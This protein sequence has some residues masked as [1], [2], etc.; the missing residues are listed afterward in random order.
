MVELLK[1][2]Y[3]DENGY[4]GLYDCAVQ[5]EKDL[6]LEAVARNRYVTDLENN[7]LV[8]GGKLLDREPPC[9]AEFSE[10]RWE[11]F[12][13]DVRY[14]R[15][16]LYPGS[17]QRVF[18]DHGYNPSPVWTM[19]GQAA[20]VL[21]SGAATNVPRLAWIDVVLLLGIAGLVLWAYGWETLGLAALIM[22]GGLLWDYTFNGGAFGRYAWLFC[23]I[24][25]LCL[26]KKHRPAA[27][28]GALAAAACL[29]VFPAVFLAVL[30]IAGTVALVRKRAVAAYV[31]LFGGAVAAG[32]L[33]VLLSLVAVGPSS[34]SEFAGNLRKHATTPVGNTMGIPAIASYG[35]NSAQSEILTGEIESL[36]LWRLARAE[37]LRERRIVVWGL[38]LLFVGFCTW[39]VLRRDWPL[40]E[41][42]VVA[43]LPAVSLGQ[44]N[45]YYYVFLILLAPWIVARP[46]GLGLLL[47]AL[48]ASLGIGVSGWPTDVRYV[49]LSVV[50]VLLTMM[51]WVLRMREAPSGSA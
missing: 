26:L 7:L 3:F 38:G 12:R 16:H 8:A 25:G 21:G 23:L 45:A 18:R 6:G 28:G 14:F 2:Q 17:W 32:M 40:W 47:A 4:T 9:R 42:V 22:G 36:E 5:A 13:E 49:A 41:W 44:I 29:R 50:F 1:Y 24:A 15:N 31:R 10:A 35:A 33:L 11:A 30:A 48:A 46:L 20:S 37:T 39:T 19:F 51:L 34:W 43:L 27:A